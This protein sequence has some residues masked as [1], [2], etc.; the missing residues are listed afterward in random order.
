MKF[1]PLAAL[2]AAVST[3]ALA[4]GAPRFFA[5]TYPEHALD[6]A[7]QWYGAL[8]G[9]GATL[10]ALTR[11]LVMLGVSAQVPCDYCVHAHARNAR[12]NGATEA[13]IR[14]AVAAAAAVRMWSTVLNGM[15]Y[16]Y[17]AFVAEF[18]ALRPMPGE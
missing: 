2:A 11:E 4:D 3:S 9:E 6:D 16:D 7:M 10:D 14:E 15:A 12:A 13:Q 8:G 17:G 18:D 5:E 1:L